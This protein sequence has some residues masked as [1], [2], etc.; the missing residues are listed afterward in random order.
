MDACL[1]FPSVGDDTFIFLNSD[2]DPISR[3]VYTRVCPGVADVYV[4]NRSRVWLLDINP[5]SGVTDSLLFDWSEDALAAPLP[6]RPPTPDQ[7]EETLPPGVSMRI[8]LDPSPT[9]GGHASSTPSGAV[10]APGND[11]SDSQQGPAG[12]GRTTGVLA[13]ATGITLA[14]GEG[15]DFEFRCVPSSLHMVP[16]PMGRYRGPADVGMGTL[17]CGTG[18]NGGLELEDLI[19][20][21]RLAEKDD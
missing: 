13:R 21:C 7:E 14:G 2:A 20:S 15:R 6:P 16:D 8:H 11:P 19:E 9:H 3:C 5:F 18:G 10:G 1:S 12:G 17:A 4:D